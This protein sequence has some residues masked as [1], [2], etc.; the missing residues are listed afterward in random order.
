MKS[1][2]VFTIPGLHSWQRPR[3]HQKG[4]KL[5]FFTDRETR[6]F[7]DLVAVIARGAIRQ[8]IAGHYAVHAIA[9]TKNRRPRDL[10]RVLNG[11]L[12]GLGKS[13]RVP[14]DRRCWSQQI[15]RRLTDGEE[16]IEVEV[17]EIE[18]VREGA[19]L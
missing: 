16:R 15:E 1:R 17:F 18:P 13:G 9:Y 8:P 11:I 3:A 10:D 14:D 2:T 6:E 7:V 12:D 5:V 4:G 19:L